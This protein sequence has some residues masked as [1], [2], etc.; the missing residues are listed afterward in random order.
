MAFEPKKFSELYDAMRASTTALTDF[1]VGSVTRTMY[2]SFAYELGLL[3]QKMQLVYLSAFVDSA[4]GT[5]LDQVV[6]ILGIQRSLPDFAVGEVVFLRDKGSAAIN[7]PAGTLVATED[8]PENP[9]KVYQ[10]VESAVLAETQLEVTVKVQAIDRGEELDTEIETVVVMPRPVPGIKSVNNPQPIRLVGRSRET[11]DELRRRSKNALLSSGKANLAA[12]ENAVLSL[13]GVLDVKVREDFH[14]AKGLVA[15]SRAGAGAEVLIAKGAIASTGIPPA[16]KRYRLLKDVLF[17]EVET[18]KTGQF[19]SLLEGREGEL[20][21]G[22]ILQFEDSSLSAFTLSYTDPIVQ[23]QFGMTDVV[24]DTPDFEAIRPKVYDAVEAV[25]A[26]GIFVNIMGA[27]KVEVDGVFRIETAPNLNLSPEERTA[28]E[29]QVMQEIVFFF[30]SVKMGLPLLF[31]KMMKAVLSV[32]GVDN[33]AE[34]RLMTRAE[35]PT[36]IISRQFVLADNKIEAEELDR[37]YPIHL[38]VASEDKR[39]PV[40]IT[41]QANGLD[42]PKLNQ[43]KASLEAYLNGLAL[44]ATIE[45]AQIESSIN[46]A[47][48]ANPLSLKIK[49]ASWCPNPDEVIDDSAATYV[50]KFV[51]KPALGNL[52]GYSSEVKLDASLLLLMPDNSTDVIKTAARNDVRNALIAYLDALSPEMDVVIDDL[53][54]AARAVKPVLDVRFEEDDLIV[55]VGT[56]VSPDR[57]SQGK[58]DIKAFEKA[59]LG[60]FLVVTDI[61]LVQISVTGVTIDIQQGADADTV[62]SLVVHTVNTFLSG[63]TAGQDLEFNALK[64]TIQNL[65]FGFSFAVTALDISALSVVDSKTQNAGLS[66]PANIRVRAVELAVMNALTNDD[67]T[68]NI[69]PNVDN[70]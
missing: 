12:L 31:S 45:R 32:E 41:F 36:G 7:I 16:Q 10:T 35:G 2:E 13:P 14:F 38:C 18:S 23:S 40:N 55:Q 47:L 49:P 65:S 3:Y 52:F 67:V 30:Q 1:E 29:Q 69:I 20:P 9:K 51:E 43:A 62:K 53:L 66:T 6:A 42:T 17:S 39:L 70:S 59:F 48:G 4:E 58:V 19:T 25:R 46:T 64:N 50:A 57:L 37:F 27:Q 63:Y 61:S 28:F 60:D 5:H 15:I 26:A 44:G 8:T 54:N 68:V 34:F 22:Q 33:L 24:V 21:T 56:V 11:D